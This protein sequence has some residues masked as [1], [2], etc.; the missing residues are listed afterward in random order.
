[1]EQFFFSRAQ[2]MR[3]QQQCSGKEWESAELRFGL[4]MA[5]ARTVGEA[6]GG[7]S[8]G[9]GLVVRIGGRL[10][11]QHDKTWWEFVEEKRR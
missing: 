3:P 8:A 11:G 5:A 10:E 4:S 1:M 6:L 7:L 2:S 9:K